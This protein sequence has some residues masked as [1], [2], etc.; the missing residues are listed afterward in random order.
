MWSDVHGQNQASYLKQTYAA[1]TAN[2][3]C[4]TLVFS[5]TGTTMA[6]EAQQRAIA[7]WALDRFAEA[8]HGYFPADH[9]LRLFWRE[10]S[11]SLCGGLWIY[12]AGL[13]LAWNCQGSKALGVDFLSATQLQQFYKWLDSGKRWDIVRKDQRIR[14][15]PKR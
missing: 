2:T 5:G 3:I 10:E 8:S 12:Q 15:P 6:S 14:K 7:E 4:G 1:F 11:A 13:A 9:G